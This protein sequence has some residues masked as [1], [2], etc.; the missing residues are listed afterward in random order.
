MRARTF[1]AAIAGAALALPGVCAA[2]PGGDS[3]GAICAPRTFEGNAYT[4]CAIDLRRHRIGLFWKGADGEPYGHLTRVPA[5]LGGPAGSRGAGALLF[6]ANAGMF[7]PDYSPAGLYVE[8]GRRLVPASTRA[9]YGNFHL[10]PNGVFYVAGTTAGVLETGAY[11]KRNLKPD[12]ATQSGP[13]LVIDG[14]LHPRFSAASASLKRRDGVGARDA[15]TL[16]FAISDQGVTFT[17]FAR[18]FRDRLKCAN[19][20]FLDGG[21]APALYLAAEQSGDNLLP[22]GPMLGVFERRSVPAAR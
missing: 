13:M 14:R 21:S 20:L 18:L 22:L 19:A 1:I 4:V 17:A 15:A 9:G 7:L 8:N 10:K 3:K 16:F 12:F 11:L 5:T 2:E 6:A